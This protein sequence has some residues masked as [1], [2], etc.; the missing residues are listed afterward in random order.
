M[1]HADIKSIITDVSLRRFIAGMLSCHH[2]W[3]ALLYSTNAS[4]NGHIDS[5]MH[6]ANK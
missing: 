1:D 4:D 2:R 5:P 6:R 3:L